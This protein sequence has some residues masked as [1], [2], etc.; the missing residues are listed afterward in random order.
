MIDCGGSVVRLPPAFVKDMKQLPVLLIALGL[1][2]GALPSVRSAEKIDF[3]RDVKPILESTCL[4]C[5]GQ[6]KP[7]GSL[8]LTTRAKAE[9]GGENGPALVPG[10][11]A[12]SPLYT[13]TIL[14]AGHDNIMPP[15]GD[16]LAKSQ[17]ETLRQWVEQGADWPTTIPLEKKVRVNF[18]KDIQPLLELN[19]VACHREGHA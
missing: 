11:P 4:S 12:K 5:H 14:P 16:T 6:E 2:S 17:A 3:A 8:Q 7:K 18:V 1:G 15:K 9:Q 10:N 19:C 13:S